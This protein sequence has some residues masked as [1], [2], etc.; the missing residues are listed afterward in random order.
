MCVEDYVNV[1]SGTVTQVENLRHS[2]VSENKI[3]D[4]QAM[5]VT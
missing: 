1:K 5:S 4:V 2:K 3:C